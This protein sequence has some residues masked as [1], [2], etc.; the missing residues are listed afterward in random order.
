M[1]LVKFRDNMGKL[2]SAGIKKSHQ[3]L[4]LKHQILQ[5]LKRQESNLLTIPVTG[6]QGTFEGDKV[7]GCYRFVATNYFARYPLL[8]TV[9]EIVQTICLTLCYIPKTLLVIDYF[10]LQKGINVDAMLLVRM[11]TV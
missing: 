1:V 6:I 7:L 3:V 11:F 2:V 10:L 5:I 4:D 8:F 9:V